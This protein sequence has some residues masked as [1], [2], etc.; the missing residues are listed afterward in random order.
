MEKYKI[1]EEEINNFYCN[2]HDKMYVRYCETCNKDICLRCK[3][4]HNNHIIKDLDEYG[5]EP[6]EEKEKIQEIEQ[7]L[8]KFESIVEIIKSNNETNDEEIKILKNKIEQVKNNIDEL[9]KKMHDNYHELNS[10]CQFN[11]KIIE[12]YN[13][14]NKLKTNFNHYILSNIKTLNFQ[15]NTNLETDTI[16]ENIFKDFKLAQIYEQ[17]EEIT[18]L[19]VER[20]TNMWISEKYCEDWGLKAG[21]REILQNQYDAIITEIKSKNNLKVEKIGKLN[22]EFKSKC[23]NKIYGKIEYDKINKVLSF[24]NEGII[25]L[26]DFVLGGTKNEQKELDLIG[27]FGEGMKLG[28]LSLCRLNKKVTIIC[29]NEKYL[30]NIKEDDNFIKDSQKKKCLFLIKEEYKKEDM[31]NQVKI[32][33]NNINE[34]EWEEEISDYLWLLEEDDEKYTCVDNW[35]RELGHMIYSEKFKEKLYVKGIYVQNIY[36]GKNDFEGKLPG[37]NSND[38]TLN[39]DR[40]LVNSSEL[41]SIISNMVSV[42]YNYNYEYLK[43]IQKNEG[44]Y[45]VKNEYGFVRTS[46]PSNNNRH[47]ELE[48]FTSNIISC[49]E[50]SEILFNDHLSEGLKRESIHLIWEGFEIKY[51][52]FKGKQP[53][54]DINS[55]YEF[56]KKKNYQKIFTLIIK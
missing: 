34:N 27:R 28:I 37:F 3:K 49:I 36:Q 38:L 16:C 2:D 50:K 14:G 35:R 56:I 7:K 9:Q 6:N 8:K 20:E 55:I 4:N 31:K 30:F 39:R 26:A 53:V 5:F 21:I 46:T 10:N 45:F 11:K 43:N 44:K 41:R 15:F 48:N 32:S 24:S 52:E 23:N 47:Y 22:F 42:C 54:Y 12:S 40:N 33:I 29:N 13:N 19:K 25:S 17:I 18:K 51:N 1:N